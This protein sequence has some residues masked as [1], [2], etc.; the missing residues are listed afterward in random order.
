VSANQ[1]AT[2]AP[3]SLDSTKLASTTTVPT[4]TIGGVNASVSF[5][6]LAPGYVGLYQVNALVPAGVA[7]SSATNVTIKMGDVTSNT[8]TIAVQ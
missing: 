4:V 5:S 6:G 2:G 1:P 3:A 7:A 8:V